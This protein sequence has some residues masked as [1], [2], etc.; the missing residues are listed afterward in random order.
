MRSIA[1]RK[2]DL[3]FYATI[4]DMGI[5]D[6]YAMLERYCPQCVNTSRLS[7]FRGYRT[8]VDISVFLYKYVR[9]AGPR[10]WVDT[11]T[12][13]LC[14]L[15]R[16]GIRPICVFDGPNPP[17]EKSKER[18]ER[19]ATTFKLKQRL[20][21]ALRYRSI[22]QGMLSNAIIPEDLRENIK[23]LLTPGR[24]GEATIFPNFHDKRSVVNALNVVIEKYE[25]QTIPITHEF[26]DTAKVI[27][28]ALGITWL[29]ADGEAEGLCASLAVKGMVDAVI[30]EDTDVMA[31]CAPVMI[32][33]LDLRTEE[34][35]V[36][37]HADI[38]RELGFTPEQL[39]DL[40]IML[41]CD[42]NE[43][44]KAWGKKA[45]SQVSIGMTRAYEYIRTYG[46]L[47]NV[48]SEL[49]DPEPLKYPRCRELFTVP[50][51]PNINIPYEEILDWEQSIAV[52]R[53]HGVG[54]D[55]DYIKQCSAALPIS[56]KFEQYIDHS[57]SI[58]DFE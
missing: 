31:Y 1:G 40:C 39:R 11:F 4:F 14:T 45:G 54:L 47:E 32:S 3:P 21:E 28:D 49:V 56:Y 10:R 17:A 55:E 50:E 35:T 20:E 48:E 52:L 37:V 58:E 5:S 51:I 57:V 23:T 33:K 26:S 43:R 25:R 12:Q 13:L 19:R 27:A 24:G 29:Q 9:S 46:C 42:Y 34:C 41:G 8:A 22:V 30:T 7:F 38:C 2:N 6:F 18:D 53:E 16:C 36:L 44:A 15:R